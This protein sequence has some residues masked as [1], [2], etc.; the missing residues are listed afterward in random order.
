MTADKNELTR[1]MES[2]I[3][4][5][6]KEFSGLRTGRANASLLDVVQV[7]AYGSMVPLNQ[8]GNVTVPEPRMLAVKVYD[9]TLVKA[10][11]KGIAN[12][13]LGLNPMPD[14]DLVRVPIPDLSEE[15][16]VELTKVAKKYAEEAKVAVRNI[17]R[18]GNESLKALEKKKEISEDDRKRREDEIQ[19]LTDQYVKKIDELLAV[20]EKEILGK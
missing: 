1:K 20:K 9:K 4:A 7:D 15:R 14:G 2:S 11:E 3:A 19:K 13:G 8:V 16:R 10:V 12:A 6:Q 18:D 17:R 5:L